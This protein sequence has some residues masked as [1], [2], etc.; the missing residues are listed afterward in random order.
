MCV[1]RFLGVMF[2]GTWCRWNFILVTAIFPATSFC[3]SP[4]RR[5]A[6]TVSSSPEFVLAVV[7]ERM[8]GIRDETEGLSRFFRTHDFI[9]ERDMYSFWCRRLKFYLPARFR[10]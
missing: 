10:V 4:L 2:G 1:N 9:N 5:V 3:S 6:M 7:A 8:S